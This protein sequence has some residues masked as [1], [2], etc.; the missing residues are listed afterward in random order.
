MNIPNCIF[1]IMFKLNHHVICYLLVKCLTDKCS[2]YLIGATD[3][4]T[5]CMFNTDL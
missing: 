2:T 1:I 5:T 4:H 3:I